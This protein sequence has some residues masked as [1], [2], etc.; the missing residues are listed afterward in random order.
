MHTCPTYSISAF[1]QNGKQEEL[2]IWKT[3]VGDETD[4]KQDKEKEIRKAKKKINEK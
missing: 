1:K 3:K 2:K 4:P